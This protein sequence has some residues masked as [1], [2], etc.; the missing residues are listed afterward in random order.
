VSVC[1]LYDGSDQ[2]DSD[3][4]QRRRSR[5]RLSDSA[6]TPSMPPA[7]ELSAAPRRLQ[8][9][10]IWGGRA[11]DVHVSLVAGRG[12]GPPPA[13]MEVGGTAPEPMGGVVLP[14]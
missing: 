13:V 8:S 4:Q 10:L 12:H 5:V 14:P 9:L 2:P 7:A 11:P 6:T 1:Q 3:S